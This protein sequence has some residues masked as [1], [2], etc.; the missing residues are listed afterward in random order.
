MSAPSGAHTPQARPWPKSWI[1]YPRILTAQN[2]RDLAQAILQ[3]RRLDK[4][5]L[6]G[7]GGHIIKTGLSPVIIDLMQRGLVT[8][9]ALNGA[10]YP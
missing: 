5:I 6:W 8:A 9:V 1:L 10:A 4:A 3:A 2:L 7:L